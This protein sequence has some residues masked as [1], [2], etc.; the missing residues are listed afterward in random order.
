M[1]FCLFG[2]TSGDETTVLII[3]AVPDEKAKS[4]QIY[5]L[6]AAGAQLKTTVM[7]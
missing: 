1:V 3:A 4:T 5:F 6:R 2:K 7:P